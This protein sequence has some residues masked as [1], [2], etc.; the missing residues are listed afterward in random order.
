M[1]HWPIHA[2]GTFL[3]AVLRVSHALALRHVVI[4]L[5][6]CMF[7]ICTNKDR[8]WTRDAEG[9]LAPQAINLFDDPFESPRR[10]TGPAIE[11]S[12]MRF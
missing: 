6:A 12:T 9:R 8:S 2:L 7:S 3:S 10:N 11:P 5:D 1:N 4:H